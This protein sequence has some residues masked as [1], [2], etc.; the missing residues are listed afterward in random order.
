VA[1][2]VVHDEAGEVAP[3]GWL[4]MGPLAEAAVDNAVVEVQVVEAVAP[5]LA[6]ALRPRLFP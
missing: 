3:A 4:Q 1:E 2:R 5:V 6:E